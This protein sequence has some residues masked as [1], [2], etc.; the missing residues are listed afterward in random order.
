MSDKQHGRAAASDPI[1]AAQSLVKDNGERKPEVATQ[2]A[3]DLRS[4]ASAATPIPVSAA[5]PTSGLASASASASES[6]EHNPAQGAYAGRAAL[7]CQQIKA[8]GGHIRLAKKTSNLF[9]HR[10]QL[11]RHGV[12]YLQVSDFNHVLEVNSEQGYAVVE[13]MTTYEELVKVTLAHGCMPAVVPELK[14]IT[15]GGALAGIGIE[16]SSFRYGLVHETVLAFDVLLPGGRLLHCSPTGEHA[17]LFYAFPN[18]YG[19]LG[20]ALKVKVKLVKVQPYVHL[21]HQRFSEPQAFY[22]HIAA[23]C[24]AHRHAPQVPPVRTAGLAEAST[25]TAVDVAELSGS[26]MDFIDATIF[27]GDELYV[28]AGR[29]V[30]QAPYTSDYTDRQIYYRS[31]QQREDDYLTIEDY[32]WRWD[33]DWFWCSKVFGAQQPLIRRLLGKRRLN[34]AFYSRLMRFAKRNKLLQLWQRYCQAPTES[35]IQDVCIPIQHAAEFLQFFQQQI[36]I[37]PVWN[38]PLAAWDPDQHYT[39]FPYQSQQLHV[40]FGFWDM[41]PTERE[42]GYYNRLIERKVRELGGM[43]SLYSNVYYTQEEFSE[44]FDLKAYRELKRKYDPQAE[45]GDLYQKCVE[46]G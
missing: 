29:M 28:S 46:K 38:C 14:T 4:S 44:I 6:I 35:V 45:L 24:Q 40:N 27:A 32:I 20:Y 7:L 12:N 10:R 36:G 19:T 37:T 15:I 11:D 1:A 43:K 2:S 26:G 5:T 42:E 23:C 31:I 13:G 9:R 22:Q 18:S 8:R 25:D 34:S 21:R 39:L 30:D 17:D 3:A 41:L 33:S 16:S